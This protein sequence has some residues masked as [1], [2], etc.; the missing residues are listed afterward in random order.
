MINVNRLEYT[1]P[2][3]EAPTVRQIDFEIEEG[4]VFGFL[5]PS[6]AGKSTTQKVLIRLLKGFR[7][8]VSV[9]GKPLSD[10][11][12]DYYNHVGVGFELPN[13][14]GKLTAEEN[15]RFFASFYGRPVQPARELLALVGLENEAEKRVAN[16]SKGMK[17]RLN[18]LRAIMHDPELLF[19]D[20]PTAGL[21]PANARRIKDIILDLKARGKT[22]FVTTH[23]MQDADQL[24]D[25]IAFLVDG[26]IELIDSPKT[27]KLK[28]GKRTVRVEYL[29]GQVQR[30]NFQLDGLGYNEAF[31][32]IL[33][34]ENVQ[35]IHTE[36]ATLEDIFIQVTGKNLI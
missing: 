29:N 9:M 11:G 10:W 19:F 25:R 28:Y 34:E 22:I 21:D 36:E 18:F 7:G 17:M 35:T 2:N 5:G 16:F 4:E 27:L 3:N 30:I 1:Y 12:V 23:N 31:L 20:E 6:G 26:R 15:L 13:H 14:Y 32:R 33:K 8:E 24:C